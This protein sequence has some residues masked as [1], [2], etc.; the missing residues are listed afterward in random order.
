VKEA[1]WI[2]CTDPKRMLEFLR[3]KTTERKLRLFVAACCRRVWHLLI[4][5]RS[6]TA[7]EVAERYA[8]GLLTNGEREAASR[9][10]CRASLDVRNSPDSLSETTLRFRRPRDPERLFR[11]AFTAEYLAGNGVGD[12]ETHLRG[13][14]GNPL[15]GVTRCGLLRCV[16]GN[17]V[18][19]AAIDPAIFR[20]NDGTAVKLAQG[21]YDDRA[22]DR[23]P[24]LADA[25]EDAGC[26]DAAFLEHL[27]G[28]GPHVRGC[29]AIDAIL[30]KE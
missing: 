11:A 29:F 18:H 19:P 16:F 21:I 9:E 25:L 30:G 14:S 8:D 28:A 6:R 4:D 7:V 13:D 22:F 23:L 1:E 10:A 27:R 5:E 24:I 2:A 3:G 20:W 12:L 17:P 15:D 26:T